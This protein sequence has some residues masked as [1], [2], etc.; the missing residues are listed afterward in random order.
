MH[1]NVD[2]ETFVLETLCRRHFSGIQKWSGKSTKPFKFGWAIY[3][4][5][6][7]LSV[8]D[9]NV[10]RTDHGN[11]ETCVHRKPIDTDKYR[12]LAFDSHHPI[13][14]K[15]SVK[16]TLFM[17]AECL[18]SSS[19]SKAFE[20]K[21]VIDVLKE[22]KYACIKWMTNALNNTIWNLQFN[23]LPYSC[24]HRMFSWP[25]VEHEHHN[26]RKVTYRV[27]KTAD[28]YQETKSRILIFHSMVCKIDSNNRTQ[29]SF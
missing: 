5:H 8:L 7:D 11:L 26:M 6:C 29:Q 21:Y 10:Y 13:C 27:L 25:S 28:S 20:R 2:G 3:S 24:L 1:G 4:I 14:H 19:D 18:P 9:L 22:N 16:K 17:R 12:Y 15:M 23:M